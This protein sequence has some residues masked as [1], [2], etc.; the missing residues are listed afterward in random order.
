MWSSRRT[1]LAGGLGKRVGSGAGVGNGNMTKA[2]L[3][4]LAA[5]AK[6]GIVCVRS[7]RVATGRVGRNVEVEDDKLLRGDRSLTPE[8]ADQVLECVADDRCTDRVA[9]IVEGEALKTRQTL[10]EA[11]HLLFVISFKSRRFGSRRIKYPSRK[12]LNS[13]SRKK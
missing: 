5:N 6:K 3:D 13:E 7:T 2:G 12:S 10:I 4:A 8:I 1:F 11:K 9:L